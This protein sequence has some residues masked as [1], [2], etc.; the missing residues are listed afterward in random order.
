[1]YRNSNLNA[2]NSD[3]YEILTVFYIS[4]NYDQVNM[5][6]TRYLLQ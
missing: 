2:N 6:Q 1:M 3:G 5:L 4:I